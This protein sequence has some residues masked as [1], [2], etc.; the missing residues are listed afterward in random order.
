MSGQQPLFEYLLRLGDSSLIL[1][2]RLSEWVGHAPVLEEDLGIANIALDLIGQTQFWLGLAAETEDAGR[3]ADQLAYLRDAS[4]FRNLLL[5][6][7]PNGNFAQTMVRQYFFDQWHYFLLQGLSK[8]SHQPIADI[9]AK[10]YKE[11]QYHVERSADWLIRLGDGTEES[12][13]RTQSAVDDLWNYT[14]EMFETDAVESD[15]VK[16]GIAVDNAALKEAWMTKVSDV[17]KQARLQRPEEDW[18]HTG[19]RK[20]VHSEHLGFL[21]AEMQFL[22]RAYPGANW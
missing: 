21:L 8:S 5:V 12:Q 7:R 16:D 17:L 11:V 4:Q 13:R 9:A 3:D 2:H 14:G 18:S 19:G 6:E 22:Q 15:L 10:S 20:G 1:G